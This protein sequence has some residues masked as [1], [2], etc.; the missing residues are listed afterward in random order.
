MPRNPLLV[1]LPGDPGGRSFVDLAM[2]ERR[3]VEALVTAPR[4]LRILAENLLW[5]AH[6]ADPRSNRIEVVLAGLS[7][8]LGAPGRQLPKRHGGSATVA[9]DFVP[10]RV[11]LQDH[12]GIPVLAELAAL[13]S[14][15]AAHGGD[16]RT[17][18]PALPVDLVVDHSV[19]A[20]AARRPDALALNMAREYALNA[21]RFRFLRWAQSAFACLR[22]TPPGHGIVHQVHLE[23]LAQ[24]VSVDASGVLRPDTV[25]GTDSHTPMVNALGVLGWGVGGIEAALALLGHPLPLVWPEVVG[26]RLR[27]A[28]AP[29]VLATDVALTMT[30]F[31]R[32]CDVTGAFVEFYGEGL[33]ALTVPDRAAVANMAPEYG[34]TV[35]YF[36]LDEQALAY[37][38][39]MGRA[40]EHIELVMRYAERQRL[41]PAGP[42]DDGLRFDRTYDFDLGG[43]EVSVAGPRRPQDRLALGSVPV[44]VRRLAQPAGAWV[45]C[46]TQPGDGAIAIAA[47]TSCTN[48]AN[49]AAMVTAG[50]LATRAARRGLRVPDWVKT[51]LAPG[52]RSVSAYLEQAGLLEGLATLGFQIVGYGCTTC[53]GNAG[54]LLP[55]ATRAVAE[56]RRLVAVLS[57][58]RNF[59]GR[60]HPD[61]AGA[62]LMSPPLVVAY[63][64]AG[65]ATVDLTRDPLGPDPDGRSVFLQDLWPSPTEVAQVLAGIEADAF[66]ADDAPDERWGRLPAPHGV[67]YDWPVHSTYLRPSP[68]VAPDRSESLADLHGARVL[69]FAP[70][71]T[72][73]DHISP[74]GP[75]PIN[76]SAGRY[77]IERGVHP[78]EL[79]TYGCRRGNHEV[80]LRGT[81]SNP[82]F[83]NQLTPNH[84]GAF[85]RGPGGAV[86]PLLDAATQYSEAGVALLILAGRDYGMG[87]SRDWAAKGPKLLGVRAVLATTFERIHRSNLIGVGIVPLQF[88][89]GVDARTLGLSGFER[90]FVEGLADLAPHGT[91]RVRAVNDQGYE[92]AW[93]MTARVESERELNYLRAGGFLTAMAHRWLGEPQPRSD[94]LG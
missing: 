79:N 72:T 54:E 66:A 68:L 30:D 63:A 14:L 62:Y 78:A 39:V 74:A 23:R 83:R 75:V 80:L 26:I 56:G 40:P 91:I 59:E 57:G 85:T 45:Q 90:F 73:T 28:P 94:E 77:L 5:Q 89:P 36:P 2:A 8:L 49:P 46:S 76:S 60:I 38:R 7:D 20:H 67:L 52:S 50:L 58:N 18:D 71:G 34:S 35:A 65:R 55:S 22:V 27:G 24:V 53:I 33:R 13:R 25:V 15:V 93:L 42:D 19:E 84:P 10:F 92:V 12:S 29:G 37:L 41:C 6:R 47:I 51:S 1:K 70:D 69:V 32:V 17:V 4:T 64:I 61:I 88:S 81:F 87:S 3:G 48:T 11:L 43:V 31:L 21:E 44:S 82:R 16:P 86:A 9:Y